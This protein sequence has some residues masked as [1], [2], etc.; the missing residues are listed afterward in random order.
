MNWIT[1]WHLLER[2]W[3]PVRRQLFRARQLRRERDYWKEDARR[4]NAN[5]AYWRGRAESAEQ[6]LEHRL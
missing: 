1:R 4:E 5:V 2:F 3:E 6:V